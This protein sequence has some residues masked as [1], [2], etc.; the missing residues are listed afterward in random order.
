MELGNDINIVFSDGVNSRA[1]CLCKSYDDF[2][3]VSISTF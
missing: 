3:D 1:M 2:L